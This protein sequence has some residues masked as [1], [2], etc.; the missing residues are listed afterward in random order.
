MLMA[1]A[2]LVWLASLI[3]TFR[4]AEDHNKR[5]LDARASIWAWARAGFI[6]GSILFVTAVGVGNYS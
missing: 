6:V 3:C 4:L 5:N 2:G 1:S